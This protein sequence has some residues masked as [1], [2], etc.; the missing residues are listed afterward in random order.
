MN[1]TTNNNSTTTT[2]TAT[3]TQTNPQQEQQQLRKK[4][5]CNSYHDFLF[6]DWCSGGAVCADMG[7]RLGDTLEQIHGNTAETLDADYFEPLQWWIIYR[8]HFAI[9]HTDEPIFYDSELNVYVWPRLHG[10]DLD[11]QHLPPTLYDDAPE[12]VYSLEN[13]ESAADD[14]T[15]DADED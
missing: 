7:H 9:E 10:N 11:D 1:E 8:E 15:D 5:S 6:S 14:D 3:A 2:T 13:P 4:Y 12:G